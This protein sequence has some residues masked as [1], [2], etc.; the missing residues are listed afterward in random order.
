[1]I[2]REIFHPDKIIYK[3]SK[4]QCSHQ[5]LQYQNAGNVP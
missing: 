5:L 2:L 4:W 3:I 1:M